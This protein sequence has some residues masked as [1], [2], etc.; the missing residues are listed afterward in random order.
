MAIIMQSL[1][2]PNWHR[3]MQLTA[4]VLGL[5]LSGLP[6]QAAEPDA[7]AIPATT[8]ATPPAAESKLMRFL[9]QDYLL[10]DWG[11]KRTELSK[12]GV[13]FEFFYIGSVPSNV[14][15]GLKH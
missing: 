12:H 5:A 14:A 8:A 1:K 15:G 9:T 4:V 2:Q 7:S 11:G 13:D 3:P 10:G 6:V